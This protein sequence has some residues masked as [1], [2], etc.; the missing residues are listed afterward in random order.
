MPGEACPAGRRPIVGSPTKVTLGLTSTSSSIT[1]DG[2]MSVLFWMRVRAP[3]TCAVGDRGPAPD[4][5]VLGQRRP[6]AYEDVVREV[7]AGAD[8]RTCHHDRAAAHARSL[9][10]H[11]QLVLRLGRCTAPRVDLLRAPESPP[12][13]RDAWAQLYACVDRH[14]RGDLGVVGD[15]RSGRD[16]E[17]G[18]AIRGDERSPQPA[19]GA[20]PWPAQ[21]RDPRGRACLE[22]VPGVAELRS[23]SPARLSA[24]APVLRRRSS[25]TTVRRCEAPRGRSP[26][27]AALPQRD[28]HW[29][30]RGRT[31]GEGW[32]R[33]DRVVSRP[34]MRPTSS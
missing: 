18:C 16:E 9:A 20:C 6:L 14:V 22:E 5:H 17:P 15:H 24:A 23:A 2:P 13:Q 34:V 27:R 25:A 11:G 10:D 1:V 26:E 7:H 3:M 21:A 32:R 28:V 31:R 8:L 33:L 29:S 4:H 30:A 12:L 19:P